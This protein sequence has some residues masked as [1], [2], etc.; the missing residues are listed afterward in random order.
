[1]CPKALHVPKLVLHKPS[2]KSVVFLRGPDGR[3]AMVYC[4]PHGSTEAQRRY[5]EV[6]SEH[7][8]GR[9]VA[10]NAKLDRKPSTWPTVE[11]LVASYLLHAQRYYVDAQGQPT[12]EVCSATYAFVELLKLHRDTPT[13]RVSVSD[14]HV[15]RQAMID[16]HRPNAHG[17]KAPKGLCRRTNNGRVKTIRRLFSWGVEEGLVPGL[18]LHELLALESTKAT[19]GV[20][21]LVP[22][23]VLEALRVLKLWMSN[24][25]MDPEPLPPR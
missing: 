17:R 18:V 2:G 19:P 6:L 25:L 1:M 4:G 3:R 23:S 12:G 7:L 16:D 21:G 13:D 10:T 22:L 5:R 14:L 9:A 24:D 20:H 8:A 11:Q 15:I